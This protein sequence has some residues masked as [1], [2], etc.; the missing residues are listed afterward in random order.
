MVNPLDIKTANNFTSK[1]NE[2]QGLYNNKQIDLVN[3]V[4]AKY[5]KEVKEEVDSLVQYK[6][7]KEIDFNHPLISKYF[8]INNSNAG[9]LKIK[10]ERQLNYLLETQSKNTELL[11]WIDMPYYVEDEDLSAVPVLPR[12]LAPKHQWHFA[13]FLREKL[14]CVHSCR[15]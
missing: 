9:T 8:D 4:V 5:R 11:R 2:L 1:F 13:V 6:G 15:G 14:L 7:F 12:A 10:T 3:A